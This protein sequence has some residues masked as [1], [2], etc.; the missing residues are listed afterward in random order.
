M[1]LFLHDLVRDITKTVVKDGKEHIDYVPTQVVT[2][3][4]RDMFNKNRKN[5]I[6]GIIYPSSKNN[7]GNSSVIFWDNYECLKNLK[8]IGQ[9][10]KRISDF[11]SIVRD[12]MDFYPFSL[13]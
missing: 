10:T 8:L 3:F 11:A 4:F 7:K 12:Y 6:E 1:I 5:R 2:E 9:E 13:R